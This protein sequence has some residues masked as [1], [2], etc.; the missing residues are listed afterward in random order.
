[1]QRENRSKHNNYWQRRMKAKEYYSAIGTI[2]CKPLNDHVAFNAVGFTHLI[3]KDGV[4]RPEKEQVRRFMLLGH[5]VN[6]ITSS[7]KFTEYR[8]GKELAAFAEFWGFE[9]RINNQVV[10]V[11]V[12]KVGN[13]QKHF[14]SIMS[15]YLQ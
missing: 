15:E 2:W 8:T 3:R 11:V 9:Q 6:I 4:L 12:R 13:G 10:T 5:A 7:L 14:F 1:M